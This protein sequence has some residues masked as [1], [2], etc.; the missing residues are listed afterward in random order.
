MTVGIGERERTT[1]TLDKRGA[2]RF[3]ASCRTVLVAVDRSTH[4]TQLRF[5]MFTTHFQVRSGCPWLNS[6]CCKERCK[7]RESSRRAGVRVCVSVDFPAKLQ[8]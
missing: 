7:A 5:L 3:A 8:E 1:E 2:A 4:C 6:E